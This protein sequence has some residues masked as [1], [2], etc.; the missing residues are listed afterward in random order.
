MTVLDRL[1]HALHRRDGA[2][3]VD[4]A[5]DL[6]ARRDTAAIREVVGGLAHKDKNIQADCIKV[7]YEVGA[8]EPALIAPYAAEFLALLSS[9]NNRLVWGGMTA[10]AA[11]APVSA[12][13][14]FAQRRLIQR[15]IETGSVI[16]QDN[17]ILALARVAAHSP[18]F[19]AE[20][21]PYLFNFLRNC[22]AK[23][24]PRHAEAIA[25]A[26]NA[27][28]AAAFA[29]ILEIHLADMPAS[30]AARVRRLLRSLPD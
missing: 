25:S 20:L 9:R 19:R 12:P 7:L 6:A 14:L 23:D 18:R 10:L 29:A 1:A 11:I 30:R 22:R 8:I 21:L 13:A 2:P 5:R 26:V 17:S 28:H 4:L 3:N 27:S 15:T 16:T 24:V